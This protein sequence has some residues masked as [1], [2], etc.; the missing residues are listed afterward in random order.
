[1]GDNFFSSILINWKRIWVSIS[2]NITFAYVVCCNIHNNKN[3]KKSC[4][5]QWCA[6]NIQYLWIS[7]CHCELLF[8]ADNYRDIFFCAYRNYA[9]QRQSPMHRNI[10]SDANKQMRTKAS[11][12]SKPHN[13]YLSAQKSHGIVLYTLW[14]IGLNMV[15]S[16]HYKLFEVQTMNTN[17]NDIAAMHFIQKFKSVPS[18]NWCPKWNK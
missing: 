18:E 12:I 10:E 2:I 1:M 9:F 7:L 5:M 11:E 16:I 15:S 14:T 3:N 8:W 6:K 17:W 4:Q 13:L